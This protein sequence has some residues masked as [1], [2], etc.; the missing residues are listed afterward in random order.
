MYLL[1]VY[2]ITVQR[3]ETCS[4]I[5]ATL[6]GFFSFSIPTKS[7]FNL[8]KIGKCIHCFDGF[9]AVYTRYLSEKTGYIHLS[10][11]CNVAHQLSEIWAS[12]IFAFFK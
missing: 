8:Q 6:Q 11:I 3:I 10:V 1:C 5:L 4:T 12:N 2:N 9:S 7:S